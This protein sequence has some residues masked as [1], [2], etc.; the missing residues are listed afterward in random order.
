[1][2]ALEEKLKRELERVIA[3][4]KKMGAKKI[5]LFGS[6]AEGEVRL[7][8]DIDLLV[9]FDDELDFKTRMKK[10]YSEIEAD[11]DF[12]ILAYNFDEFEKIKDRS[13]FRHI[14][15]KGKVLYEA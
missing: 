10:L 12:D 9:L 4:L 14:L 1:M 13:L 5:I 15:R 3:Q 8:S 2:P 7:G 6:L 11:V